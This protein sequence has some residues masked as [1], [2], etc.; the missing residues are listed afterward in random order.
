MPLE[1]TQLF[2]PDGTAVVNLHGLARDGTG[3]MEVTTL[4]LGQSC[5]VCSADGRTFDLRPVELGLG[6]LDAGFLDD[7]TIWFEWADRAPPDDANP[8]AADHYGREWGLGTLDLLSGDTAAVGWP[9]AVDTPD[10]THRVISSVGDG[11]LLLQQTAYPRDDG[12]EVEKLAALRRWDGSEWSTVELPAAPDGLAYEDVFV[13][14]GVPESLGDPGG[15]ND[16]RWCDRDLEGPVPEVA[17]LGQRVLDVSGSERQVSEI[18]GLGEIVETMT[19]DHGMALPELW[20]GDCTIAV[21][22]SDYDWD[23]LLLRFARTGDGRFALTGTDRW[24][25]GPA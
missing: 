5:A 25:H 19:P 10:S 24:S 4:A 21:Q 14:P 16:H 22:L 17:E 13:L 18:D 8:F 20:L 11:T 23:R 15:G 3:S 2:T 12:T 1:D 7:T 9:V 6:V